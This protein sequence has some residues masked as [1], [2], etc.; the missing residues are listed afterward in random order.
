[1]R[2]GE[3]LSMTLVALGLLLGMAEM[4]WMMVIVIMQADHQTKRQSPRAQDKLLA[5]APRC[6]SKAA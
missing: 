2:D 5:E 4:L 6:E 3:E 1:M